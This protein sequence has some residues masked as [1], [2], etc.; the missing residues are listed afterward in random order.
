[1]NIILIYFSIK[2]DGEWDK[3]YK[4]LEEK[5]KSKF[6]RYNWIGRKNKRGKMKFN[7]NNW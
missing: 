3:I 6:K 4:A 2:Y 5:R 7:N 1:M